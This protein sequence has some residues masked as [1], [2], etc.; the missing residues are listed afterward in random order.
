MYA[1]DIALLSSSPKGLQEK[2][3]KLY[4]SCQ[5]W[6]LEANVSKTK[7]LIFNKLRRLVQNTSFFSNECLENV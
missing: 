1:D 6:C 3:N 5:D 2:L 4:E 7:V